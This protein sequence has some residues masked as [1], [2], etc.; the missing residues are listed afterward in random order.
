ML[1]RYIRFAYAS[2][3]SETSKRPKLSEKEKCKN[4]KTIV[5]KAAVKLSNI[6]GSA[7]C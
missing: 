3:M 1:T 6:V 4:V 5:S 2:A 7:Y